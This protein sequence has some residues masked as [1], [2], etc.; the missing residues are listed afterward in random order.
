[1]IA[2]VC[3]RAYADDAAAPWSQG[4][5]AEHKAAAKQLLDKGNTAFLERRYNDA[6]DLYK[7]A[8]AEWDHPAIR[9]NIVRCLIQLD[10]PVDATENLELALKYG[11]TPLE[12]AVYAEAM[13]YRKLLANQ[14]GELEVSCDQRGLILTLD[15]QPLDACPVT[16]QR[17]LAVGRHQIVGAKQGFLT[18]TMDVVV[19]GGGK[20]HVAMALLPLE[21]TAHVV[22]RW[23]SWIPWL[24]FGGGLAVVGTGALFEGLGAARMNDYDRAL[25][26]DCSGPG[27][28]PSRPVPVADQQLETS[29]RTYSAIGTTVIITGAVTAIVGGTMLYLNRGRTVYGDVTPVPGGGAAVTVRGAF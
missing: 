25:V 7:R 13:A 17:R 16:Q 23:P 24:V 3:S 9:F 29:A 20:E 28:G 8:V 5:S 11:A 19:A 18:K 10:R 14:T 22:Q 26:R 4:V 15:G 1:V 12:D 2:V 27:C 21:Q 6:L